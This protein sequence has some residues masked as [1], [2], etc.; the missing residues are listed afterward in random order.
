MKYAKSIFSGHGNVQNITSVGNASAQGLGEESEKVN[1][2]LADAYV[3][4]TL[5]IS[6]DELSK[7]FE[8]L[9]ATWTYNNSLISSVDKMVLLPEYQE[10]I[11]MGKAVVPFILKELKKEPNYWFWALKAITR[12][13]PVKPE[14]R[15]NLQKMSDA[16]IQWGAEK[17]YI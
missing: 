1:K 15:G 4:F 2:E 12:D 14:D 9:A 5:P 10:I 17:G 8:R 7:K 3:H 16:W 13:D 6:Q 11:G